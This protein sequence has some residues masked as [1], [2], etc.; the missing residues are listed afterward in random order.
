MSFTPLLLTIFV[1]LILHG[2]SQQN[3]WMTAK[4]KALLTLASDTMSDY[5]NYRDFDGAMD[6]KAASVL[7]WYT[8]HDIFA[9]NIPL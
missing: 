3:G 9:E 6:M 2:S 5:E 8:Q 4:S 7:S 1:I